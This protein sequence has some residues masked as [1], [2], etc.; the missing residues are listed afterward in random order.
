MTTLKSLSRLG[1]DPETGVVTW[2]DG[3]KKG[4]EAG[5]VDAYGYRLTRINGEL[6]R[7][8]HIAWYKMTGEWPTK[9][10]DHRDN[11]PLNNRWLNLRES[12]RQQQG[13]NQ[14]L[15]ER[16]KGKWKG[17]HISSSGKFYPKLKFNQKSITGMGSRFTCAREAAMMYNYHAERLFGPFANFN[18]VFEDETCYPY[19]D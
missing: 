4:K 16:R 19:G 2:L 12:N 18:L 1:Y 9:E 5:W 6:L 17:V 3:G 7:N 10:I 11:D 13:M 15:Q 8:H 14:K